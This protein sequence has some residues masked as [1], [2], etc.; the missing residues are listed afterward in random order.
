MNISTLGGTAPNYTAPAP[1][2]EANHHT[3]CL[4]QSLLPSP[5]FPLHSRGPC[6]SHLLHSLHCMS[7]FCNATWEQCSHQWVPPALTHPPWILNPASL[8]KYTWNSVNAHLLIF[9]RSPV[10]SLS[11]AWNAINPKKVQSISSSSQSSYPRFVEQLILATFFDEK[12]RGWQTCHHILQSW[13]ICSHFL[14]GFQ[15]FPGLK[16]QR[17]HLVLLENIRA[18]ERLR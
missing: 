4:P 7:P 5:W 11:A 1:L 3:G 12:K 18:Q 16:L 6:A 13:I 8:W 10:T 17:L 2:G 9:E 15:F 14:R